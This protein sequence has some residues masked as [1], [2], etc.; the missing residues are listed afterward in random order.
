MKRLLALVLVIC[1]LCLAAC[2][3]TT[4]P[5]TN[6]SESDMLDAVQTESS[7][8]ETDSAICLHETTKTE[9]QKPLILADGYTKVICTD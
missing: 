5:E 4:A 9:E 8:T 2:E 1:M 6:V 7:A 3:N